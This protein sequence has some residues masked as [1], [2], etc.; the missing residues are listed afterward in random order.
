MNINRKEGRKEGREREE[1]EEREAGIE[2]RGRE[3]MLS[4]KGMSEE[5]SGSG[6]GRESGQEKGG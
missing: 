5:G 2:G 3:M 6:G 1:R 4:W